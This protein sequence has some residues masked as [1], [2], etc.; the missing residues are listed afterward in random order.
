MLSRSLRCPSTAPKAR[1]KEILS[2]LSKR[3]LKS[4]LPAAAPAVFVGGKWY[5]TTPP[6]WIHLDRAS[7]RYCDHRH[8]GSHSVPGV[9]PGP[10]E[11]AA[12]RLSLELQAARPRPHDVHPGL[13]RGRPQPMVG[14]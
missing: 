5:E 1:R 12:D 13:R 8:P 7:C 14:P 9:C 3:I 2:F 4:S 6:T 11:G 10:G